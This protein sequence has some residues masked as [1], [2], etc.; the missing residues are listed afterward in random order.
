MI[1]EEAMK[2]FSFPKAFAILL[3]CLLLIGCF[4]ACGAEAQGQTAGCVNSPNCTI[5]QN[6]YGATSNGPASPTSIPAQS[7]S[8]T[9]TP[10]TSPSPNFTVHL[11]VAGTVQNGVPFT[12]Q[13][14]GTYLI[15]IINGA[16]CTY[17]GPHCKSEVRIYKNK[18]IQWGI[19]PGDKD[20]EPVNFDARVGDGMEREESHALA[21]AKNMSTTI[22]LQSGD[23]LLFV[24]ADVKDKYSDNNGQVVLNIALS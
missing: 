3:L 23:Q 12:A 22:D 21:V 17:P 18:P 4:S 16:Y 5:T 2:V 11:T 13:E 1:R 10:P 9:P 14:S 24:P 19:L 8:V 15:T 6:Q 20:T 7:T